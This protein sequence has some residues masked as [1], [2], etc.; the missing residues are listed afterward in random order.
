MSTERFGAASSA[1][2]L[3]IKLVSVLLVVFVSGMALWLI[4]LGQ[5]PQPRR[6][7]CKP[8]FRTKRSWA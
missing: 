8:S 3:L 7:W 4:A 2:W 1:L 5:A 6:N